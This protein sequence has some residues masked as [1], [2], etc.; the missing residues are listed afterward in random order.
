MGGVFLRRRLAPR[1]EV[2]SN[3]SRDIARLFRVATRVEF[4]RL[5]ATDPD[6]LTDLERL[7]RFY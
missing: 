7:A 6:T 2:I 1:L 5:I 4:E 3:R